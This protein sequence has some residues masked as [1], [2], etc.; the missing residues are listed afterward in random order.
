MISHKYKVIFYH[1]P[2]AAGTSVEKAFMHFSSHEHRDVQDHRNPR[3]IQ[4]CFSFFDVLSSREN[5]SEY[6][7]RTYYKFR[8][9]TNHNNKNKV[10]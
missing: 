2:K 1:I 5:I 4:P 8:K 7:K 9:V 6:L 10:S 3:N